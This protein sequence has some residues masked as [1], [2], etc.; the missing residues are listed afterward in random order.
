MRRFSALAGALALSIILI[1]ITIRN[2]EQSLRAVPRN[3]REGA[4]ALGATRWH[5]VATVIVPAAIRA[6]LAGV[7]LGVGRI[8]GETAPLLFT[9][10]N[11]RYWSTK[12]DQPAASL[13]VMIFTCYFAL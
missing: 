10:F 13:P 5:M 2:A 1:P 6:L 7:L 8:A 11:N 12:W 9:S 4:L 3:L